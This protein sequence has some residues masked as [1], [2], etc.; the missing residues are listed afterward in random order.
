MKTMRTKIFIT[1]TTGYIGHQLTL[2]AIEMGFDVV[3]LV[4]STTSSHLPRHQNVQIA[5]GDITNAHEVGKAMQG[6]DAVFHTAAITQLWDKDPSV[7]YRVNVMGTKNVL[8]AALY[9]GIGKM[10]FTSSCGVL[11]PSGQRPVAEDHPRLT[12]F[13]NDYEISKYCA[14]EMIKEYVARGLNVVIVAPSR[15]YG[16]GLMTKGNPINK[17]IEQSM[18]RR[19]AFMPSSKWAVGNYAFIDD[20]VAGHFLA[21]E[22]GDAG[23]KYCLGGENLSYEQF[24][25]TIQQESPVSV[26][27]L[28]VPLMLLKG[29][30]SLVYGLNYLLGRHTHLT[31]Q[32]VRRLAENRAVSCEKAI[33]F[34]GYQ[35]TPFSEGVRATIHHLQH[36]RYA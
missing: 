25:K 19:L 30:A 12:P 18:A 24:F 21:L 34:L 32:V 22:K 7:F 28:V 31:P 16:P 20:V 1:G 4:R 10:V 6:C 33:R 29:W 35:I 5:Q 23:Q 15:V 11:G 13:E 36:R 2:K 27:L 8:D 3:A 26:K 14:E 17:L 9:H